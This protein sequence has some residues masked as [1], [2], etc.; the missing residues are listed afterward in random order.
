MS[1]DI[2]AMLDEEWQTFKKLC[3]FI[4]QRVRHKYR[5]ISGVYDGKCEKTEREGYPLFYSIH[6]TDMNIGGEGW[7]AIQSHEDVCLEEKL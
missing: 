5:N 6:L 2:I 3:G 7:L 1:E 4:G